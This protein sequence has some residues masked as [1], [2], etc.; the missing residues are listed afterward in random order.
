MI[1]NYLDYL[2]I[3]PTWNEIELIAKTDLDQKCTS[4][5]FLDLLHENGLVE[6]QIVAV[7]LLL[8]DMDTFQDVNK[9]QLDQSISSKMM[10]K[11]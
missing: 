4:I 6:N 7:T 2:S 5:L 10:H 11:D 3:I 9:A 8:S 1:F